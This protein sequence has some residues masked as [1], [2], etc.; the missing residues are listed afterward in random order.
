VSVYENYLR[1]LGHILRENALEAKQEAAVGND[2]FKQGRAL[3]YY[4]VISLLEQQAQAF[5]LPLEKLS[6]AGFDPDQ[7]IGSS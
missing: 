7:L 1:D 4:E 6:L 3:A 2:P 5:Q